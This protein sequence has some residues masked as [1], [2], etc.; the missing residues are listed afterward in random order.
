MNNKKSTT[1]IKRVPPAVSTRKRYP[2][3]TIIKAAKR[4]KEAIER[5]EKKYGRIQFA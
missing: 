1:I 4:V 3:E 5:E 2:I